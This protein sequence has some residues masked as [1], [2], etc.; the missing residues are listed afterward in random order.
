MSCINKENLKVGH[1]TINYGQHQAPFGSTHFFIP[2][3]AFTKVIPVN[4]D[5]KKS[6]Q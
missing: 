1:I 5:F 6:P 2:L 4:L 3:L